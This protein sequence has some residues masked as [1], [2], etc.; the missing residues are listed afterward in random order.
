[1]N[2]KIFMLYT[3]I[4]AKKNGLLVALG[5]VAQTYL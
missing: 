4:K 5:F 2:Y 3:E 1:M